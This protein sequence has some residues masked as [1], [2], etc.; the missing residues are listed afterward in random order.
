MFKWFWTIFSL[1]A[2]DVLCPKQ[3]SLNQLLSEA[4]K[5]EFQAVQRWKKIDINFKKEY[6]FLFLL[7]K[8]DFIEK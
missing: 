1:G 4:N 2:P 6:L 8:N 7:K 5:R 3:P